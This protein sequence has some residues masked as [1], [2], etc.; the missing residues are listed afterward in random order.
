MAPKQS[1][2]QVERAA[3][4]LP[5]MHAAVAR[6][7]KLIERLDQ[8]DPNAISDRSDSRIFELQTAIRTAIEKTFPTN[9]TQHQQYI[10]ASFIDTASYSIGYPTPIHE[11]REGLSRGKDDA[12]VLLRSAI[13][14]LR[15]DIE[16]VDRTGAASPNDL[17]QEV[18]ATNIFVVH[19]R[20]EA[21]KQEVA[22][23]IQRANLNPIILHEQAS[24]G[25]TVIEKLERHSDIGFSVV[26]LTPD[27]MGRSQDEQEL[28]PRARQNVI[29]EL[30][31][32]LGK[33]GRK[34]VCA[35]RKGEVEI[36]TDIGGVIYIDFDTAGGWKT[37]LLRELEAAGYAIN[38]GQTLR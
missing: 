20:D 7:E 23:F 29:A 34:K 18:H 28:K 30:F 12:I 24:M 14:D 15:E 3:L 36:P 2:P 26:L 27:D 31:Y 16:N 1:P 35:L 22:R 8:F 6:F 38:W 33:L 32:F 4:S 10:S 21:A 17:N 19:G 5:Q 25:D 37:S 11:V 13:E 9:S